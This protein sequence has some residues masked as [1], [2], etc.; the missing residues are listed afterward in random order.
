MD[1]TLPSREAFFETGFVRTATASEGDMKTGCGICIQPLTSPAKTPCG[2]VFDFE[3]AEVWFDINNTCPMCRTHLYQ[4]A[5]VTPTMPSYIE[6]MDIGL[7]LDETAVTRSVLAFDSHM[8]AM[9]EK[10]TFVVP[11]GSQVF[12]DAGAMIIQAAG[13]AI[14]LKPNLGGSDPEDVCRPEWKRIVQGIDRFLAEWH[15][16]TVSAECFE[17][18]L[19][20]V[21]WDELVWKAKRPGLPQYPKYT[22]EQWPMEWDLKRLQDYVVFCGVE[23]LQSQSQA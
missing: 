14:W 20:Q 22:V 13:A 6:G 10:D 1:L 4:A 17:T 7:E 18:L 3:C 5:Q 21:V 8:H 19:S 23:H 15:G 16:K 2:H 11:A 9:D 12:V